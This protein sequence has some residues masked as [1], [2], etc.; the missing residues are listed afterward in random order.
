MV[1]DIQ[2]AVYQLFIISINK[3]FT[4]KITNKIVDRTINIYYL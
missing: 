2:L 1:M 3:G 4:R